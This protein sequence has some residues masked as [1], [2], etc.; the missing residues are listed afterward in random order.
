[1]PPLAPPL[2]LALMLAVR[3]VA[4][5]D[6]LSPPPAS[7]RPRQPLLQV[8][9]GGAFRVAVSPPQSSSPLFT[10][11]AVGA[12]S[13]F[14]V[15]SQ[16]TEAGP[17]LHTLGTMYNSS[18]W[19]VSVDRSRAGAGEYTITAAGT[20]F[21][22]VRSI[23]L[24]ATRVRVNDTITAHAGSSGGVVGL[25]VRHVVTFPTGSRAIDALVPGSLFLSGGGMCTNAANTDAGGI[26]RGSFG[27]PASTAD[28]AVGMV[29]LDD[30][31]ETHVH[32]TQR[33]IPRWPTQPLHYKGRTFSPC[34]VASPP[35]VEISDPMLGLRDTYRQEWAVYLRIAI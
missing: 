20:A 15:R 16:F 31:F 33:A 25:T 17:L 19:A 18:D 4:I 28:A 27:N 8:L 11:G 10:A 3:L 6:S 23:A 9:P 32:S 22:L 34:S 26:H 2:A 12:G 29:A 21:S 7:Q 14:V 30:V 5:G 13:W 24:T 1:M 35:D